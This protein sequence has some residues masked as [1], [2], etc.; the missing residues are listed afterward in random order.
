ML[1]FMVGGDAA[2]YERVEPILE[3]IG[4]ASFHLGELGCGNTAKLVNSLVAFATTAASL[5]A[6]GLASKAGLDLRTTV[7]VIRTGGAGNFYTNMA[8]EG[9]ERRSSEPQFALELAAK[10]ADL[11]LELAR[12]H[13]VPALIAGR[14]AELL[15]TAV[16]DGMG[17]RDW[18]DL[19]EWFERRG[20]FAFELAPAEEGGAA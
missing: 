7:D 6:L 9:I 10:D 17:Q 3:K 12:S 16:K 11:I 8:V 13:R 19:P 14:L 18:T 2:V 20:G 4:R 15:H 5:E 1:M